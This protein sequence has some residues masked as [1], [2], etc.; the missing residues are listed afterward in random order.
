MVKTIK[1]RKNVIR[2]IT[3]SHPKT[4]EKEKKIIKQERNSNK[5]RTKTQL[6]EGD[7]NTQ[8]GLTR[9]KPR[10]TIG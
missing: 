1:I 2:R 9:S 3:I 10:L 5:Y 6:E 7:W 4:E 8:H